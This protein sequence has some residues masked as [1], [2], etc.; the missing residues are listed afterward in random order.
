MEYFDKSAL[1]SPIAS[2]GGVFLKLSYKVQKTI[3]IIESG[4]GKK[5]GRKV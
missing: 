5:R 2:G 3:Q 1:L 4:E